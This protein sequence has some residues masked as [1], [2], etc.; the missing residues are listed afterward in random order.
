MVQN[1]LLDNVKTYGDIL[2]DVRNSILTLT[3][4]IL[5]IISRYMGVPKDSRS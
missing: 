2:T 3:F 4:S 1:L 5:W